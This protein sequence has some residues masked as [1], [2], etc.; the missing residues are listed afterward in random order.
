MDRESS[1]HKNQYQGN[2]GDIPKKWLEKIDVLLCYQCF[3]TN[4]KLV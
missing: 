3:C 4:L 1:D 2:G